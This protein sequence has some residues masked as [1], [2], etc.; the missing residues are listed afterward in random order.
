MLVML[1]ALFAA[2]ARSRRGTGN[3]AGSRGGTLSVGT[4]NA[5]AEHGSKHEDGFVHSI[6]F[7]S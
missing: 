1:R 3:R 4:N 2:G 6:C 7:R 5:E